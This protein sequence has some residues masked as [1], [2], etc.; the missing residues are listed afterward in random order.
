MRLCSKICECECLCV[1]MQCIDNHVMM[2]Y[3]QP[4][5]C[6]FIWELTLGFVGAL[7]AMCMCHYSPCWLSLL[8]FFV[9]CFGWVVV[10]VVICIP[11][12][13]WVDPS[14]YSERLHS[15]A[16]L[17]RSFYSASFR[18]IP[19]SY[20]SNL[21]LSSSN[22]I[23]YFFLTTNISYFICAAAQQQACHAS[24]VLLSWHHS[25]SARVSVPI[26]ITPVGEKYLSAFFPS[27]GVWLD[28]D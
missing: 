26:Q 2:A 20:S 1:C 10:V 17:C 7:G 14:L 25:A 23:R 13:F 9:I 19:T 16:L 6:V 15:A 4:C 18:F 24:L 12:S 28:A 21:S 11:L 5:K 22:F 27:A 3:C 8:T